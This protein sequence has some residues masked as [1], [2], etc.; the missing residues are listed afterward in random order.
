LRRAC[1]YTAQGVPTERYETTVMADRSGE[2]SRHQHVSAQ[3]LAEK[4]LYRIISPVSS[5]LLICERSHG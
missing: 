4:P 5:A 3:R 2:F 1:A